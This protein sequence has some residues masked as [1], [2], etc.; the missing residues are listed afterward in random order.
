MTFSL[1][2]P[3]VSRRVTLDQHGGERAQMF[4]D[5]LDFSSEKRRMQFAKYVEC[6]DV[7]FD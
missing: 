5:T 2:P 1:I 6:G 7:F 3:E 4:E